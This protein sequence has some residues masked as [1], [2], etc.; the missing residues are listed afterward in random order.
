MCGTQGHTAKHCPSFHLVPANGSN[1]ANSSNGMP[2]SWNPQANFSSSYLSTAASWLLDSGAS[3]HVIANLNNLSL[4]TPYN[5]HD[6]DMLGDGTN[7]P[8]SH[9]GSVSLPTSNSSFKLQDVL[10]VPKMEKNL[11][12]IALFCIT[13]NVSIELFPHCF[14]VKDL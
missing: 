2:S 3:H 9:T 1:T 8:I 13:N 7:L 12:S 5:G 10:C 4:Q 11:I 14:H 6:D